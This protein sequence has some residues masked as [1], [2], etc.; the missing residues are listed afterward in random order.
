MS[1]VEQLQLFSDAKSVQQA[2]DRI[3]VTREKFLVSEIAGFLL[4]TEQ[5]VY[6]LIYVGALPAFNIATKPDEKAMYRIFRTDLVKFLESRKE[7]AA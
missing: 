1:K 2:I 5:H 7:G 6:N 4:C 3:P